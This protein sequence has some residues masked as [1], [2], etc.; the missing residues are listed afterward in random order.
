MLAF[1][2]GWILR[3]EAVSVTFDGNR[4][5][6]HWASLRPPS[7]VTPEIGARVDPTYAVI[8]TQ[9][10]HTNFMGGIDPDRIIYSAQ[11]RIV[12]APEPG[13]SL[14]S[15]ALAASLRQHWTPQ[16]P[17]GSIGTG[18]WQTN[19]VEVNPRGLLTL[20]AQEQDF[21]LHAIAATV[22]EAV[23]QA[24]QALAN[25]RTAIRAWDN[26]HEGLAPAYRAVLGDLVFHDRPVV[27][28]VQLEP[29]GDLSL[30]AWA[31]P[32]PSVVI[33]I[34][35]DLLSEVGITEH[36]L[37]LELP[38]LMLGQ[39][40]MIRVDDATEPQQ[41]AEQLLAS[42]KRTSERAREQQAAIREQ[43]QQEASYRRAL[44]AEL[45]QTGADGGEPLG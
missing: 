7:T 28:D 25:R 35:P 5:Q 14:W 38:Q 9:P 33:Q 17:G 27:S 23:V 29:A 37:W 19:A 21:D 6:R 13:F 44:F 34:S 10:A 31:M 26:D 32:K 1:V 45:N 36:D 30:D 40:G 3:W 22:R 42:L 11:L 39:N 20:S 43:T 15:R 2:F 41:I 8:T 16:M 24:N 12:D 4:L 18:S